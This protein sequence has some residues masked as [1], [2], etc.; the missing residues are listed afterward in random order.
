M[1]KLWPLGKHREEK[2]K[3]PFTLKKNTHTQSKKKKKKKL[4]KLHACDFSKNDRVAGICGS[5]QGSS[6]SSWAS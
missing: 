4:F 2:T 3:H 6:L 5:R 1:I